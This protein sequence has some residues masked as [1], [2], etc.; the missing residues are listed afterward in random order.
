[1]ENSKTQTKPHKK[2]TNINT[3]PPLPTKKKGL[4]LLTLPK[5]ST[6]ITKIFKHTNINIAYHTNNTIQETLTPK[7]HNHEKCS[8]TG[9]YKLTCP[10]CSKTYT[11]Q[12]QR[13]SPEDMINTCARSETIVIPQNL[14]N[15]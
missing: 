2:F 4:H 6:F 3:P 11:G 7:T 9:V 1:M 8:A 10:D 12:P 5:Q 13:N 14:P 15:I